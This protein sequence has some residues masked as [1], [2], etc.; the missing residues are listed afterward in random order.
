MKRANTYSMAASHTIQISSR[1]KMKTPKQGG[2]F[3]VTNFMEK[4]PP[5]LYLLSKETYL[6]VK[7][8]FGELQ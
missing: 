3:P 7:V 5:N 2:T 1:V 6:F 8:C 4:H